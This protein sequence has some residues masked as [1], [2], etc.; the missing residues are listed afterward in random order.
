MKLKYLKDEPIRHGARLVKSGEEI[1]TTET[2]GKA[3][4]ASGKFQEIKKKSAK[5][6][7]KAEKTE[8]AE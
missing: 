2:E 5:A 6:K 1:E 8:G 4:V 7:P 3:L